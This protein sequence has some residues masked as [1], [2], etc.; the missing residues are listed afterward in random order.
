MLTFFIQIKND[1]VLKPIIDGLRKG[2]AE[3]ALTIKAQKWIN[4]EEYD[5][6]FKIS[7]RSSK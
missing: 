5:N 6:V 4:I 3:A 1:H 7:G 2:S